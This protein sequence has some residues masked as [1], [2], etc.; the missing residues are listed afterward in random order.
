MKIGII[1]LGRMGGGI[2]R[3]MMPAENHRVVFDE[4]AARR[5]NFVADSSEG[6]WTIEAAIDEVVPA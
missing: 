2:A 1:A 4:D 5:D 6:R 3:R